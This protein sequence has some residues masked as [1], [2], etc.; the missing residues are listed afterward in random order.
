MARIYGI[1]SPDAGVAA[2][3]MEAAA[4][5]GYLGPA[6]TALTL[7]GA[8]HVALGVRDAQ[9]GKFASRVDGVDVVVDGHIYNRNELGDF[10]SD[11]ELIATLH[12]KHG[13]EGMLV[14][15]NGDF[16]IALYDAKSDALWLAR[17]RL[18]VKPLYP[19]A[20]SRSRRDPR[21]S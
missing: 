13:F 15:L 2:A 8:P 20:H 4:A 9:A 6:Q 18:G 14:R 21:S 7:T 5:K 17:D 19:A 10:R 11:A 1:V 16:S 3:S 12:R